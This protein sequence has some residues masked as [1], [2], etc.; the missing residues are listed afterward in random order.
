MPG[1]LAILMTHR[2]S[3]TGVV[4]YANAYTL[5]GTGGITALGRQ[6]LTTV[7]DHEPAP[8]PPPWRPGAAP[9]PEIAPLTGRW[10]WMGRE[11]ELGWDATATELL[12]TPVTNPGVKPWRFT[13][14]GEDRWRG[15]SGEQDGEILAICRDPAGTPTALNIATFIFTRSPDE[16]VG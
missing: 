13:R 1:Y 4:A 10:W 6:L 7:L 8:A 12:I 9:P 3:R 16:L 15:R 11:Y 14:E 5:R 2:A